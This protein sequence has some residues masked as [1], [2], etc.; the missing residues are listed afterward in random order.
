VPIRTPSAWTFAEAI[1]A[2]EP[3]PLGLFVAATLRGEE[4][5]EPGEADVGE[6]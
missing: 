5:A 3:E 2:D 6:E 1:D 4:A